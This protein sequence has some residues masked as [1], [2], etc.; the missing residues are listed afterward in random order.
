MVD[1]VEPYMTRTGQPHLDQPELP[2]V[3]GVT[4]PD[5]VSVRQVALTPAG[6][7]DAVRHQPAA[8]VTMV[9]VENSAHGRTPWILHSEPD[10][11]AI[12][13]SDHA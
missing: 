1:I 4:A 12:G 13:A 8:T 6:V 10:E 5:D 9:V 3:M 7:Q 2:A 11:A